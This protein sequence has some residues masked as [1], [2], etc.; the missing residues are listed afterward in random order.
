LIFQLAVLF[1]LKSYVMIFVFCFFLLFALF[2]PI[3]LLFFTI[4]CPFLPIVVLFVIICHFYPFLYCFCLQI[5]YICLFS[6]SLF[7]C[8]RSLLAC[9]LCFRIFTFLSPLSLTLHIII[10]NDKIFFRKTM[11]YSFLLMHI[12]K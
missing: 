4:I 12:C 10:N 6:S 8:A 9:H 2:S 7:A 3:F 1:I 11:L 5:F